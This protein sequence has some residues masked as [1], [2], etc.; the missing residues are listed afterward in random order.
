MQGSLSQVLSLLAVGRASSARKRQHLHQGTTAGIRDTKTNRIKSD[1]SSASEMTGRCQS[2]VR[3][4]APC[5]A[6]TAK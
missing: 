2:V 3:N 4:V 1:F 6:Q 5:G